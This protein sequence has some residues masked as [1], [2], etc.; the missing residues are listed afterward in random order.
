MINFAVIGSGSVFT[1]ELVLKLADNT[2]KM[3]KLTL[4][5][6]DIDLPRQTV[7]ADFCRRI[8]KNHPLGANIEIIE[9]TGLDDSLPG[10][11]YVLLQLRQGGIDARIEDEKL[12]RKYNLPF[13][14]TISIC[15]Y[16]T[17]L[18]TYY[19]FE[20]VGEAILKHAPN[21][22]ILNFTNPAGQLSE[23][24]YEMGIKKIIGVCNGFV[25][26]KWDIEHHLKIEEGSYL[27][28]WR[29]LNHLTIVDGVYNNGKNRINELLDKLPDKH[30]NFDKSMLQSVGAI[31]NSYIAHYLNHVKKAP[32]QGPDELSLRNASGK[33][34]DNTA[35]DKL[36]SE[37]VK[38]IDAVLLEEY[39]TANSVPESLSKRGGFG[40]SSAVVNII[41]A[42]CM[43]ENSIHY[44]VVKN[45]S[46]LPSLPSD[47]FVEVPILVNSCGAF[48]IVT[49]DL[50][51]YIKMLA[52]AVKSYERILIKAARERDKK[53]M[54]L[55]MMTH[56][57]M[58]CFKIAEPL[59]EECLEVN[60][61]FLPVE[62]Y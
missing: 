59:L 9:C 21:A 53:G 35:K 24:L 58:N 13:T 11:D 40:Y 2:D 15:G 54:M 22:W 32:N 26:A 14:E 37:V 12:G 10:A 52:N 29:G 48:P 41:R 5:F 34:A 56:P 51:D 20:K 27:M 61:P 3:G 8:L 47:A 57:L 7:L 18:R 33:V 30:N 46:C 43:N 16:A 25:G 49:D 36:R 55:A 62:L 31:L 45:G 17:F 39:K 6:M 44:A 19:E 1:P 60:R 42:I 4:R 50:P 28:N 23:T 38:E